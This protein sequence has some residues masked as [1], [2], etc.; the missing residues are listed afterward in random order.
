MYKRK[1]NFFPNKN[2][3][4]DELDAKYRSQF[5]GKHMTYDEF[6][7]AIYD[8]IQKQVNEL[9][10]LKKSKGKFGINTGD[11]VTL[12]RQYAIEHGKSNLNNKYKILS[13]T[14]KASQVFTD[15]NDLNE[16]GYN[17]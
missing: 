6:N 9:L 1:Y 4:I 17:V 5:E 8:D 11:W 10:D 3:I 2:K 13:K 7:N 16:W 15:G 12:N 14:V